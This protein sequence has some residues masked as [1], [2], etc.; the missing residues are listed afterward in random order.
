MGVM[1]V[2]PLRLRVRRAVGRGA[3]WQMERNELSPIQAAYVVSAPFPAPGNAN[4][5]NGRAPCSK[6]LACHPVAIRQ[7]HDIS[8]PPLLK[9]TGERVRPPVQCGLQIC[10][11]MQGHRWMLDQA[12]LDDVGLC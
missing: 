2:H 5:C 9:P 1:E 8:C 6:A 10:Q 7:S 11:V 12:D 3:N 4:H